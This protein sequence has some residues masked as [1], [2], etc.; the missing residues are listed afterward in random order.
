MTWRIYN[1]WGALVFE[2]SD[3]TQGWDGT[4][5]GS[6]QPKEVYHYVLDV[7]YANNTKF[8]KRGDIT[9]LR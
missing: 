1:R 2:T 8:Q 5:K 3:R 7:E 9:L 4:Y 6:I